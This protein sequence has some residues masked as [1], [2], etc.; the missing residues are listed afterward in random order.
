VLATPRELQQAQYE[1]AL[2]ERRYAACD[3][4]NGLIAAQLEKSRVAALRRVAAC[5]ARLAAQHVPGATADAP[6]LTGLAGDLEAAWNA[7]D[8]SMRTRQRLV[9]ALITDIVADVDEA[10][11]EVVLVIHRKGGQHAQLRVKKPR[12]GEHGCRTSG[13]ALA[14]MRR[15]AG[16]WSDQHIAASLNRMGMRTGQGKSWT[17]RRVGSLRTVH[18]IHAYRSAVKNGEWL[19]LSEAAKVLGVTHH[20]VRRLIRD[21]VLAAEQVV[22]GAPNQI[23]ASDL[24][25]ER[26]AAAIKQKTRPDRVEQQNQIAT[27]SDT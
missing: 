25:D 12:S 14:V 9:R 24:L 1:A 26:V 19:T 21:R 22:R 6:D 11:R 13:E 8:T 2:A 3:P 7:P 23:K 15:M 20:V 17:A 10:T 4:D 16:R 27:F 5:E 18:G